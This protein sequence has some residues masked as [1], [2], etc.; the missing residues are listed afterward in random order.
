MPSEK[1]PFF[2]YRDQLLPASEGFIPR[3]YCGFTTLEPIFIGTKR[4]GDGI[5][6]LPTPPIIL[7]G[8]GLG[9]RLARVGFKQFGRKPPGFAQLSALHPA[10]VHAQFGR[11]GALAL[12]LAR[13]LGIPLVITFHGGDATKAKHYQKIPNLPWGVK[14][15]Y[16]R[17]LPQMIEQA[18]IIHCVSEFIRQTLIGRG[19]P[20]EK[21]VT[22]HLGI[23]VA[24]L[25][26]QVSSWVPPPAYDYSPPRLGLAEG[27]QPIK[28]SA[29]YPTNLLDGN[30]APP[31]PKPYIFAAGR[32][33]E[34]K[35]FST[36]LDALALLP[37][38]IDVVIAGDGELKSELHK[39]AQLLDLNDR[40]RWLGWQTPEQIRHWINFAA[41]VA[42]P[43]VTSKNGDAEGLPS[44]LLE[45]MS[46][47]RPVIGTRHAGI[48]EAIRHGVNGLL[49]NERDAKGLA[50]AITQLQ[51]N[52]QYADELGRAARM[53]V[54]HEFNA[55]TQ[56]KK[57]EDLLLSC[58]ND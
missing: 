53:T 21:L 11:G 35:G 51:V 13:R 32:M 7:G 10:L 18:K 6:Q 22:L 28:N 34:K 2:V 30:W 52:P 50:A 41:C 27:G 48:P 40:V 5:A 16:L 37:P 46:Q 24:D 17:R 1:T 42:I 33:V 44:F 54:A 26:N 25:D 36:L 23:V 12:P 19:F 47:A 45:A 58:I 9:G 15:I 29:G 56:S 31:H 8:D 55:T 3:H 57:F 39:Q 14:G 38:G 43:S 49:V 4:R 20:P